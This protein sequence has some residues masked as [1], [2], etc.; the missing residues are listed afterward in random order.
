M[1]R[2]RWTAA[3]AATLL[4]AALVAA[5]ANAART[6][7]PKETAALTRAIFSSPVAGIDTVAHKKYRVTGTKISTVSRS[8]ATATITPRK[9]YADTLQGGYAIAV[10]PAGT[11]QW[12]VVD[13]GSSM[14]GCGIAPNSVVADLLGVKP[15]ADV[16]PDGEGVS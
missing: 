13:F 16:C 2:H 7:T 12:V 6:A 8:W 15:T 14:V 9:R 10:Q 5:P 3:A 4:A 1:S 11:R